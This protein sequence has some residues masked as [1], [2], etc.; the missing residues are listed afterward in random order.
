[1]T[2]KHEPT[3]T[4]KSIIDDAT[5]AKH[6]RVSG[7]SPVVEIKNHRTGYV[8]QFDLQVRAAWTTHDTNGDGRTVTYKAAREGLGLGGAA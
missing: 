1:M 2:R 6:C 7:S 3:P 5:A 4:V 8:V